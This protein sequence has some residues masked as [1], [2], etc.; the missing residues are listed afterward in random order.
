MWV[1]KFFAVAVILT[2][3]VVVPSSEARAQESDEGALGRFLSEFAKSLEAAQQDGAIR[4]AFEDVLDREPSDRELRR[5]RL[6]MQE[7]YWTEEDV[8]DDLEDRSDYQRHS[9]RRVEDPD[10]IIRRAYEDILHREPDHEG[11]RSYRSKM[12]DDDWTEHDVREAL[13]KS[14]EY[15]SRQEESADKIIHRAYD[16]VLGR[17]PDMNGLR[18]YRNEVLHHGWDEHDVREALERS[19][20]YRD[21]NRMTREQAEQVVRRAYLGV[22][23]REPDAGA[24]GYV[25][26]VLNDHWNEEHVARELR[27][28]DE[29]RSNHP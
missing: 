24:R 16:D 4:R 14:G 10:R 3:Q 6:R 27:H 15:E 8:R 9:K 17:E 29:Y 11:L 25:D 2:L 12:I 21:K 1:R 13:R 26:R 23:Q 19:P 7:D 22:L 18:S 20:E 28:S 5:Y